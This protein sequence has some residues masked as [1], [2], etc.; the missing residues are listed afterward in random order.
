M[1]NF[2]PMSPGWVLPELTVAGLGLGVFVPASNAVIIRTARPGSASVT[3]GLADDP[4]GIGTT[5]A[6]QVH[7]MGAS[8]A[9]G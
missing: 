1:L 3:D 5:A 7:E 4:R 8:G 9:F 6:G 2:M